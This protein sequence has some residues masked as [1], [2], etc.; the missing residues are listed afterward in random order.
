MS[1]GNALGSHQGYLKIIGNSDNKGLFAFAKLD[2]PRNF[3]LD[4]D[5]NRRCDFDQPLALRGFHR[6]EYGSCNCG[7]PDVPSTISGAHFD[8][9]VLTSLFVA[10]DAAPAGLICYFE[11]VGDEDFYLTQRGNTYT[12]TLQEQF[13]Y[14]LEWKNA[15]E[16]LG[17]NEEIAITAT[18]MCDILD[19][20]LTIQEWILSEV[21]NEK[22]NR[23][24]EG[25]TNALERTEKPIP[26]L[27][28]EFKEWLL[29]KFSKAKPFGAHQ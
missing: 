25:K 4:T 11:F 16:H 26:D 14:L 7:L 9:D 10:V 6:W 12:R 19:I 18:Q 3:M 1:I 8:L 17:N 28:D 2:N 27:T 15:H 22:V 13:R 20:P 5:V 23:F 21:P 29:D 24:L